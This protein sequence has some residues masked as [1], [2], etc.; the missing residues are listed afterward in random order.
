MG[1]QRHHPDQQDGGDDALGVGRRG[2]G[3]VRKR[4]QAAADAGQRD[5]QHGDTEAWQ[6]H[7]GKVFERKPQGP[8]RQRRDDAHEQP[9]IDTEENLD[10][11]GSHVP[12]EPFGQ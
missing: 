6:C 2:D 7:P 1:V 3:F 9:Q 8:R 12:T 5:G 11:E 4:Q 10:G